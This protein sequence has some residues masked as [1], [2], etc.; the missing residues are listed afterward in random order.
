MEKFC[1][2]ARKRFVLSELMDMAVVDN[3]SLKTMLFENGPTRDLFIRHIV[4][5]MLL[6]IS[7]DGSQEEHSDYFFFK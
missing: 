4:Y 7:D 1:D 6:Q 2:W 5:K 3:E